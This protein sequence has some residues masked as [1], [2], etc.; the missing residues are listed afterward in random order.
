MATTGLEIDSGFHL[1]DPDS[2]I[3]TERENLLIQAG[4][5][6]AAAGVTKDRSVT[7]DLVGGFYDFSP[8]FASGIVRGSKLALEGADVVRGFGLEVPVNPGLAVQAALLTD[9]GKEQVQDDVVQM[10]VEGRYWPR[11]AHE[12]MKYHA[13]FS[14]ELALAAGQYAVAPILGEH[15][16]AQAEPYG[17][18][19]PLSP[20]QRVARDIAASSDYFEAMSQRATSRNRSM[21]DQS[22]LLN[23]YNH[24]ERFI[25]SSDGFYGDRGAEIAAT[26]VT[27]YGEILSSEPVDDPEATL[28]V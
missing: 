7:L 22:R 17:M 12:V 21:N 28:V 19:L 3:A 25:F 23:S 13:R 11:W 2:R 14:C 8:F 9:I 5:L 24:I 16:A 26:L 18:G 6:L 1:E 10:S 4:M 20:E 15:H 27:H